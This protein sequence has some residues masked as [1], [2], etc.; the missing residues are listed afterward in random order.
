MV[1]QHNT[2][3]VFC[4]RLSVR[5]VSGSGTDTTYMG[6]LKVGHG[7]NGTLQTCPFPSLPAWHVSNCF[8]GNLH[9]RFIKTAHAMVSMG[10]SR[11]LISC[12]PVTSSMFHVSN[13]ELYPFRLPLHCRC[14]PFLPSLAWPACGQCLGVSSC[15]ST[16]TSTTAL[17][18][19][20]RTRSGSR[21][22]AWPSSPH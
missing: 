1:G 15:T 11:T 3:H 19:G 14:S 13:N 7:F 4:V 6:I 10:L 2:K 17:A 5:K 22:P 16:H 18:A 21:S 8:D 20:R 12:L 9:A